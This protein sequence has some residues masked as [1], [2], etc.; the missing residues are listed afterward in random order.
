MDIKNLGNILGK[1]IKNYDEDVFESVENLRNLGREWRNPE[2]NKAAFE[3]MVS[4]VKKFD[5]KKLLGISRSFSNFL[6]LTNSADNHHRIRRLR[7]SLLASGS[8]LGLWPKEDSSAGSIRRLLASGVSPERVESA[9]L[10]QRVE[11]VLT[12]HPTE[13]NR[14]TMLRKHGRI[15]ELLQLLDNKQLT[16]FDERQASAQLAAEV[17]SI[18]DS[19]D[20]RRAKPSPVKEAKVGLAIV[21]NVLWHSVPSFLRKLDDVV[22]EEL[23]L[24]LPLDWA[25]IKIASWM[26]GDRDGNPNVTPAI[27]REVSMLS[28][29]LGATLFKAD[30]TYLHSSLS[31]KSSSDELKAVTKG[32]REPYRAV[33]KGLENRLQ[34]TI[35]W[36]TSC[37]NESTKD[38]LP[39]HYSN[40][41]DHHF[42]PITKS[43]DLMEPLLMLHRSLIATGKT[44]IADGA[45]VDTIRRLAAFGMAL[46]PLDIRQ[47][48]SRH[49]EALVILLE[50]KRINYSNYLLLLGF[51]FSFFGSRVICSMG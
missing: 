46:M 44:E 34:A 15:E 7:H 24:S 23:K 2:G 21:E 38:N 43:S 4:D 29:W 14:R 8:P 42:K 18:W 20:L 19:D 40:D 48:S 22:K 11:L 27:T 32:A 49:T 31:L 26:G 28:R 13:V 10:S 33:L 1:S 16:G 41:P 50:L 6:A 51:N 36:T 37:L 30:I 45:L 39:K 12:A 47:E 25:P 5:A 9:L 35:E 3:Q 17:S